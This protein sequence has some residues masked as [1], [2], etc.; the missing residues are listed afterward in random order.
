MVQLNNNYILVG[1]SLE[2]WSGDK[3][4]TKGN[5]VSKD[6]EIP[7]EMLQSQLTRILSNEDKRFI[8]STHKKL[9][10]L[11]EER[12]GAL[13]RG[14]GRSYIVLASKWNDL[15]RET[16][17]IISEWEVNVASLVA[18][19]SRI[20][21]DVLSKLD[22]RS[23]LYLEKKLPSAQDVSDEFNFKL[24]TPLPFMAIPGEENLFEQDAK[25]VLFERI[26]KEA[27]NNLKK[28]GERPK[29]SY[30]IK[31]LNALRDLIYDGVV[32]YGGA[33]KFVQYIDSV[34]KELPKAGVIDDGVQLN[35]IRIM[36]AGLKDPQTL[37]DQDLWKN[38]S[39]SSNSDA[40]QSI[41]DDSNEPDVVADAN[42]VTD[43]P[44]QPVEEPKAEIETTVSDEAA[45]TVT[46]V[47][48]EAE[49]VMLEEEVVVENNIPPQ[50]STPKQDDFLSFF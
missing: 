43:V 2:N 3:A 27:D 44:T 15:K 9:E 8:W 12:F 39:A 5:L 33:I 7:A 37:L 10:R 11:W 34:V 29:A 38:N 35:S 26:E 20:S 24:D 32:L 25:A 36:L 50:V 17:K 1:Y 28:L 42:D 16:D 18:D 48:D 6:A 40:Q 47:T 14:S 46:S 30:L 23:R 13:R 21:A 19:Y 41:D 22:D 4:L 31:R 45:E 49:D